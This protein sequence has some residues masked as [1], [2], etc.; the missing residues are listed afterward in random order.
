[1]PAGITCLYDAGAGGN[2]VKL[3]LNLVDIVAVHDVNEDSAAAWVDPRS[4]TNWLK[5]FLPG[6]VR[7]GRVVTYGYDATALSFFSDHAPE[8]VQRL[9]ESL[10][11]ELRANRQFAGTLGR[12]II[13]VCHGLGGVIVKKSLLYS[14]TRNA[15]KVVHLRDQFISTFAILFFGTPHG[16]ADGEKWLSLERQSSSI[17]RSIFHKGIS[18]RHQGKTHVQVSQSVDNE[19]SPLLKQ[20][21]VFFFWAELPSRIG[22]HD[23]FVVD[24]ESAAPKLDNTE[25]SGIHATHSG[26]VKFSSRESSDYHTVIAALSTYCQKAPGIIQHR[27]QQAEAALL[28]LRVGEAWELGGFGFDV[29]SE[30][31]FRERSIPDHR[32]FYP[33]H[34]RVSKFVGRKDMLDVIRHVFL[35]EEEYNNA[36]MRKSFVVFG[37]G[38]SGKTQLCSQF[39][40][41]YRKRYA[42]V[43][44]IHAASKETITDSFS[45]IGKLA[46]LEPTDNAG[47]HYLS[48]LDKPWLLI[49]DNADDRSLDIESLFPPSEA[50]HILITTRCPDFRKHGSLGALELKGLREDEALQL[51][52]T[53]ADIPGPWDM[54]TREAGSLITKTLGYLALAVIQAG[55]CIYRR[56]CDLNDYLDLHSAARDTL[57]KKRATSKDQE[58]HDNIVQAVYS[59]FDVSLNILLKRPSMRRHDASELLK[60]VCFFHFEH[61]PL[62]LFSRAVA[63][64]IRLI[65]AS[66]PKSFS[67]KIRNHLMHRFEPP[68]LLPKFLRAE[69]GQLDKY[70]MNWAVGELQSLS[71]I[72]FDGRYISLHPLV[73]A[74]ARDTLGAQERAVWAYIAQNTLLEAISLPPVGSS[75]TDGEFHRDMLPHLEVSLAEHGNPIS[76]TVISLHG[77]RMQAAKILQPTVLLMLRD[78]VHNAAKC[79]WVFAER[80]NFEKASTHLEMVKDILTEALGDENERTQTS[81]LGLA[82]VY[83]GLGRLEEAIAL[84]DAVVRTRTRILGATSEATLQAMDHLGRSYW[85]HGMYCEALELQ[86]TTVDRM[87]VAMPAAH[88]KY[89][90]TVTALDN[91][92]VTLGSWRKFE[93]SLC[94]HRE[95]LEIRSQ[96]LGKTHLDTL[97]T[98]S[99]LA[100]AL[101]DLG[102]IEEA[103]AHMQDVYEKR[104]RQL[105]R[106]HPWTLW[107][108]CYLAKVYIASG[109]LKKAEQM[110]IW[111]IEAGIRSLKKDHLGVLMGRGELARVYARGGRLDEAER[112]T[113]ETLK[114][115]EASRGVAHPD[116]VFCLLK[117][118][119]LYIR[120]R[121]WTTAIETCKLALERARMRITS[122]HP[123][124]KELEHMLDV[125]QNPLCSES[126]LQELVPSGTPTRASDSHS[127]AETTDNLSVMLK[128]SN[129]QVPRNPTW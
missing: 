47:R 25:V 104:R 49:I 50:A 123:L 88:P 108:L 8:T 23:M 124:A 86:R 32:H 99:N 67:D 56:I 94:V 26:M 106:E 36:E 2:G 58:E 109:R 98:K 24:P 92:G 120:K 37:M 115:V 105:G 13:F 44:T 80:G 28:Q 129:Y 39:A 126:E 55:N 107:A 6:D 121:N 85:L 113:L 27:W 75:E 12:P 128:D 110:L 61:V 22:D 72:D 11:Q 52:L 89:L 65:E 57:L 127:G 19:F 31:P 10:V 62:E 45:R 29:H 35:P 119:Q 63:S 90:D 77:F 74:W 76:E 60:L 83:W 82:G 101:L 97:A 20:F 5:D 117:L 68:Q 34:G 16:R 78:Q 66:T 122:S 1:M 95:V 41:Q 102:K 17:G 111:G 38:G 64:R 79:G 96:I 43:F 70:R 40:N 91:L 9:A 69:N 30:Q 48:Q 14:S 33:P 18:N 81:M 103:E 51:L 46:G 93:E 112:L 59:S 125:L 4:G 21:H 71:L 7:V 100:M 73:H 116:C 118:A 84:Q 53:K 3:P 15:P 114:M 87:K 42:A 54:P